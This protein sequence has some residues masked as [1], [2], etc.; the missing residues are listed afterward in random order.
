MEI[1]KIFLIQQKEIKKDSILEMEMLQMI[2][3]LKELMNLIK[4]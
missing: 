4:S 1:M 2:L 3:L